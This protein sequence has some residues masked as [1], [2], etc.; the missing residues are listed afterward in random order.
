MWMLAARSRRT[1][2]W[3]S[4]TPAISRPSF[5]KLRTPTQP[6]KRTLDLA[7]QEQGLATRRA[8]I[9][10]DAARQSSIG[11]GAT[12]AV[13]V[14]RARATVAQAQAKLDKTRNDASEVKNQAEQKLKLAQRK[15]QDA[16]GLYGAAMQNEQRLNKKSSPEERAA[17]AAQITQ[18]QADMRSA[19][20]EVAS[21]QIEYDTA[22]GNEIALIHD[23]EAALALA[24]AELDAIL[25]G[26]DPQ[27]LDDARHAVQERDC[28]PSM[29]LGC[30]PARSD[31]RT[32]REES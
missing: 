15:L 9:D 27:E 10:L 5:R 21:S 23:A 12:T 18:A 17:V 24:Q 25:N 13:D 19:E 2:C 28:W 6:A 11:S 29:R 32:G 7:A 3:P 16:L 14:S 20:D 8:Q 31:D 22:H 4:S 1:S 30:A 26:P